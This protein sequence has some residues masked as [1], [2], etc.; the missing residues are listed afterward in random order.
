MEVGES[1]FI[2]QLASLKPDEWGNLPL[3]LRREQMTELWGV[4]IMQHCM[5]HNM[6]VTNIPRT[7]NV[8]GTLPLGT[9][10]VNILLE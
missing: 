10:L 3:S 6:D 8:Y 2:K 1:P 5:I 7:S 4:Q 9:F